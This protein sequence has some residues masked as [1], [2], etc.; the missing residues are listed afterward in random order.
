MVAAARPANALDAETAAPVA[1]TCLMKER[2][3][4]DRLEIT[5]VFGLL[6]VS[7]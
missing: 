4:L 5:A 6:I 2:R 1:S 3:A 7:P